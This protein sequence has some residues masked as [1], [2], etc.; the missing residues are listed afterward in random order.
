MTAWLAKWSGT[1]HHDGWQWV[2]N[3]AMIVAAVSAGAGIARRALQE[4]KARRLG[5]E[6]LVTIAVTGALIIGE[7]WE[8]AA[9]TFLFVFGAALEAATLNRT[10]D[11]VG[12]LLDLTPNTATVIRAGAQV[13]VDAYDV[14]SGEEV[15]VKAGGRIPVDGEVIGGYAAVDESSITGESEPVEKTPGTA[16]FAGTTLA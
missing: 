8:A 4:L 2:Y 1:P 10:R 15:L 3:S 7:Y 11:A 14:E 13:E 12:K 16:V 6:L 5:I 9:V